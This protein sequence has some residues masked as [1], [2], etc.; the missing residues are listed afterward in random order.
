MKVLLIYPLGGVVALV[1]GLVALLGGYRESGKATTHQ[2][3][4][5]FFAEHFSLFLPVVSSILVVF[6][7]LCMIMGF[8]LLIDR[9]KKNPGGL[10]IGEQGFE[11]TDTWKK[12]RDV[13]WSDCKE[14]RLANSSGHAIFTVILDNGKKLYIWPEHFEGLDVSTVSDLLSTHVQ[15]A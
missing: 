8:R 7:L 12:T 5:D 4:A 2:Y 1:V 14:W 6:G 13:A 9:A 3:K 11:L 10:Y 15:G